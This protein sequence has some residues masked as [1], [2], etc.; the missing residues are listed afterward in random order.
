M[1]F[2]M[3]LLF[4]ETFLSVDELLV[5]L[6][7]ECCFFTFIKKRSICVGFYPSFFCLMI[8]FS[9]LFKFKMEG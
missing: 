6:K 8:V 4:D 7:K 1:L 3:N 9:E 2:N 5:F